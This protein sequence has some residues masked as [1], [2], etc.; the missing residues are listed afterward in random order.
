MSWDEKCW[1]AL[2]SSALLFSLHCPACSIAI[3]FSKRDD[4]LYSLLQDG[5]GMQMV[6][7]FSLLVG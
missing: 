3:S 5:F 4:R 6:A 2:L 7:I 1:V